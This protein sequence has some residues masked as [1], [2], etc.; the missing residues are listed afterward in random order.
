MEEPVDTK[1]RR[2]FLLQINISYSAARILLDCG[3]A[4]LGKYHGIS[5]PQRPARHR[6]AFR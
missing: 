4:A 1:H 2:L 5:Q 3:C 6:T